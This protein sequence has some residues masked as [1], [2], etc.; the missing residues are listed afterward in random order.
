MKKNYDTV[1]GEI[2][3]YIPADLFEE[4]WALPSDTSLNFLRDKVVQKLPKGYPNREK[5]MDILNQALS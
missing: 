1:L 3:I 2:S 5:I 4:L